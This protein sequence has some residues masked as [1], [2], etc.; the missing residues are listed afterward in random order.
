MP[1]D[2]ADGL[3]TLLVGID[4]ASLE[5]LNERGS[6]VVPTIETLFEEG[7][8]G[9]LESQ[10]PPWTP[11][12]WPSVYTGVNPGK[13]GVFGFLR[14]EGYDW[15]VV[16]YTD[17]RE[18]A[19][20]ELLSE[21]GHSSVVVNAPVT[22][23]P[24][25]FDGALV[26][27]YVAPESPECHPAGLLDDL[28]DELG[29]YQLYDDETAPD[30]PTAGETASADDRA[31]QIERYER[32]VE[33][34]GEAFRYLADRFEPDFGFLQ[35]QQTDTVFHESPED[36]AVV[37]AV[38]AAA[39]REIAA[40][41]EACDPD[42][43]VCCSDHGI[44][45]Y[46]G[47]EFR[48]NSF[49]RDRGDLATT[50]GDGG[51]PS[52]ASIARNELQTGGGDGDGTTADGGGAA[53]G[54]GA[55]G[56]TLLERS[57]SVAARVG[58]T[59]QRIGRVARRLGIEEQLLAIAPTDAVRAGAEHVDFASSRAYVRDRIELGV[60]INLEGREPEGVVSEAEY[61]GFRSELID[62]LAAVETPD[63]KPVFESVV[64]REDVFE[65]PYV[66][67]APDVVVVPDEFDQFL[68]ASLRD[69]QFG[70]PQEPWNHKRDGVVAV[71]GDLADVG[72]VDAGT[73]ELADAH[74]FDVAPT[75][76]ATFGIPAPAR[77]DGAVLP[78]V[79]PAG[80]EEYP[81]YEPPAAISRDGA[82]PDASPG[83]GPEAGEAVEQR[84]AEMGYLE[85]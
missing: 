47:H 77:M 52:W 42:V 38:Y 14:F 3:R 79:D 67:K 46:G 68:S 65:G 39:D 66:E 9:P 59:S 48:A 53:G 25:S 84:L 16:D 4:G 56:S 61:E 49:L 44:G 73:A 32:L 72:G 35:F 2:T 18:H 76:L 20:W 34:R 55:G 45:P 62:A 11:S 54:K 69:E 40:T 23:P 37:D 22:H 83:G 19:I 57:V 10:L 29:E 71:T 70:P 82:E 64:R 43:V 8:S 1:D 80:V 7:A 75:I 74:L 13:H 36:D 6:G 26:P 50:A 63:G 41:I 24:A 81:A 30:G 15:D 12:A 60:R 28:E 33:S 27:G 31:E 51:M 5:V 85:R 17:V 58:L 21:R 78:A